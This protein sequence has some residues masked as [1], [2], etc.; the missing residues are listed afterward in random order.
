MRKMFG[1]ISILLIILYASGSENIVHP[2]TYLNQYDVGVIK[3][4][5]DQEPWKSAYNR[6]MNESVPNAMNTPIQTVVNRG[7]VPPSGDQHDYFTQSYVGTDR[8]DYMSAIAL[9]DAVRSLGLAYTLTGES[10]YADKAIQLINGWTVDSDTKMVP[11]F[12][13]WDI[14]GENDNAQSWIELSITM[15]GVFYGADLIWD[16]PGWSSSDKAAFKSWTQNM[17]NSARAQTFCHG[18]CQNHENWRLVFISSASVIT[19]DT[20]SM[21]YTFNRWK[22]LIPIQ[23]ETS[24]RMK[25]ELDRGNAA[26]FY[27]TY[28]IDAMIQT[29]EIAK[30]NGVDLYGYKLTDG[31]GLEKALD[32]HDN[33]IVD[34]LSWPNNPGTT[35]TRTRENAAIYELAYSKYIKPGYKDVINVVGRPMYE[36][37]NMGPVTL[38]HA[39]TYFDIINPTPGP[40]TIPDDPTTIPDDPGTIPVPNSTSG[41]MKVVCYKISAALKN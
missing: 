17:I 27:S 5:I 30:H 39:D 8:T 38:T 34:P 31:R 37:R 32:Y 19:G 18:V 11:R 2:N 9:R 7:V 29:A 23:M 22:E 4:R 10:K 41:G 21:N 28:A 12:M 14:P 36:N 24:G 15:P 40:T 26:L 25:L 16:Y 33:Y 13:L 3:S 35:Q 20:V 6:L 1:L